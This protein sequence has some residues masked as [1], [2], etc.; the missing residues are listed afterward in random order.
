MHI[1]DLKKK[2]N[3]SNCVICTWSDCKE[4][5][6]LLL[7]RIPAVVSV[8]DLSPSHL[9]R[10]RSGCR[11][12]TIQGGISPSAVSCWKKLVISIYLTTIYNG[13]MILFIHVHSKTCCSKHTLQ[14][15]Q[16][17]N[18]TDHFSS[19]KCPTHSSKYI[20]CL[21]FL[22]CTE[23]WNFIIHITVRDYHMYCDLDY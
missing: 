7:I 22:I 23:L 17:S 9:S 3:T 5:W 11:K 16:L 12:E 10:R 18:M 15:M 19:V 2:H 1:S 20:P 4:S 21:I 13:S 8:S 6:R 14:R